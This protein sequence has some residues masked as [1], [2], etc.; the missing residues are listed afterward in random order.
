MRLNAGRWRISSEG[1]AEMIV[2]Q[3][4]AISVMLAV[5]LAVFAA[6]LSVS[7]NTGPAAANSCKACREAN[8]ACRIKRKGHPSCDRQLERCLKRCLSSYRKKR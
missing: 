2:L 8:N 3:R 1:A 4:S 6:T 5:V 7:L